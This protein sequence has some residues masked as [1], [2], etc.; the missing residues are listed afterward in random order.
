M[1][2]AYQSLENE[3]FH[4]P[5]NSQSFESFR[6]FVGYGFKSYP[7]TKFYHNSGKKEAIQIFSFKKNR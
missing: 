4:R 2:R 1:K 5:E 3:I 7:E 6:I